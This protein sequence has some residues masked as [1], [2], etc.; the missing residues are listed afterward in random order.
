MSIARITFFIGLLT[1]LPNSAYAYVGPGLGAGTLGVILGIIGSIFI[2]LF[3]ICWYP[4]K[5]ILKKIKS[6]ENKKSKDRPIS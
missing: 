6:P 5:R 2:A 3:A 4:L 1:I